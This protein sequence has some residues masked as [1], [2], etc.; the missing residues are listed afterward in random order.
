MLEA[1]HVYHIELK[2]EVG[3]LLTDKQGGHFSLSQEE[4]SL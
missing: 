1:K 4:Q 2:Q 3:L